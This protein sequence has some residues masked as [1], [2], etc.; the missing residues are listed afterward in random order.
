MDS[1]L[2]K[3]GVKAV[4]T[5]AVANA[6][7][8]KETNDPL[9]AI[10]SHLSIARFMKP[11]PEMV[12]ICEPTAGTW[13]VTGGNRGIGLALVELLVKQGHV[14]YA[15]CR[16]PSEKLTASGASVIHGI[17]MTQDG[18][19]VLLKEALKSVHK[20]DVLVN[21]AGIVDEKRSTLLSINEQSQSVENMSIVNMRTVHEVNLYGPLKM[22]QACLDKLSSGSK[23]VNITT[24]A[25]SIFLN[26]NGLLPVPAGGLNAYRCSKAA[27]NMLT[28]SLSAELEPKGISFIAVHPGVPT[29]EMFLGQGE[30]ALTTDGLPPDLKALCITAD[31]AAQL[32]FK[33]ANACSMKFNGRF[34]QANTD[35]VTEVPW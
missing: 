23:V 34:V 1:Y 26:K 25:G 30:D 21:M 33:C 7:K 24:L 29:T 22:I 17:D 28:R 18:F 10:A 15:V 2:E 19:G 16:N 20:I 9:D 8:T 27:L 6:L 11:H 32:V 35:G 5:N 14:V 4:L 12:D 31:E 13:V 3:H